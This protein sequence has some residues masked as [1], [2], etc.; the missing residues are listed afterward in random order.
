MD[1]QVAQLSDGLV[2]CDLAK[3]SGNSGFIHIFG[4]FSAVLFWLPVWESQPNN[5]TQRPLDKVVCFP[6]TFFPFVEMMM[7]I[8]SP[9]INF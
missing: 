6:L 9:E 7:G 5:V 2:N 8:L 1:T 4:L 3:I